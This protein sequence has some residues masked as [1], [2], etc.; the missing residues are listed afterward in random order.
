MVSSDAV[1]PDKF[2]GNG[3]FRHITKLFQERSL[4]E[5]NVHAVSEA[6][7]ALA[8]QLVGLHFEWES[9]CAAAALEALHGHQAHL[10]SEAQ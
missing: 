2:L 5:V 4:L 3:T 7:M 1:C 10:L 6:V 8:D 9:D